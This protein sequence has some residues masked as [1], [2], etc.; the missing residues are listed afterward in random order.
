[1][2]PFDTETEK[3]A[4]WI[5][6][7]GK[8]FVKLHNGK[9]PWYNVGM[10]QEYTLIRSARKTVGLSVGRGGQ[11]IVRAPY[12]FPKGRIDGF[13]SENAGWI[14]KQREKLAKERREADERGVL[15][16]AE[17]RSL[18]ARMKLALPEKL[19]RYS[20]ALGVRYGRV[21]IR[22][23]RSKWGSCTAKGNLNFNCLL[24]LAP[25]A[26]LDYVVI[27]ELCHLRHMDHSKAFWA[28]VASLD[29]DHKAHRKWLRENG[30]AL[31]RRAEEGKE[32]A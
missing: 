9:T 24:M 26:V 31:L 23:Q 16:P 17:V 25:E 15:T 22:C 21:T 3:D 20:A 11:V 32:D 4:V 8:G 5:L 2:T 14:E 1:M 7:H 6:S 19:E 27:H 18:A 28:E 29:P 13:V 10:E 12:G 30:G